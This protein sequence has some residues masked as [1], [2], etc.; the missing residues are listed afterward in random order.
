MYE[1]EVKQ[2]KAHGKGN[3]KYFPSGETYN[4]SWVEG[5]RSGIGKQVLPGGL[6]YEG[7][8]V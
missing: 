4:G 5:N 6:T 7:S 1:G 2:G 8:W 3:A